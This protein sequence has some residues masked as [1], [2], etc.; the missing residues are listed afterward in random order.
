MRSMSTS[1]STSRLAA[2]FLRDL[3]TLEDVVPVV[4]HH[5]EQWDGTGYPNKLDGQRIP[6]AAR[7]AAVADA[8][9][10]MSSDRPYRQGMSEERVDEILRAGA[11][12]QWDPEVIEAFFRAREDIRRLCREQ[13]GPWRAIWRRRPMNVTP[14]AVRRCPAVGRWRRVFGGS[15]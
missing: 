13:R 2:T 1:S 10:A 7:I 8:F 12:K 4:L 9:D 15:R 3:A 11:G 6:L 5:H 14:T